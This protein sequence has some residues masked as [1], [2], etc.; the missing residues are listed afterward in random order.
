MTTSKAIFKGKTITKTR[1][2]FYV[3]GKTYLTLGQATASIK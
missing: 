3:D 2:G 1:K